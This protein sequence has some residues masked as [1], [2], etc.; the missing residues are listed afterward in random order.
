MTAFAAM[1][2]CF[3]TRELPGAALNR[4]RAAHEV[5]TW[6]AREPPARAELERVERFAQLAVDNL[7][8]SDE[9]LG[10][11]GTPI[12]IEATTVDGASTPLS[13]FAVAVAVAISLMFV[14][15]LLAAG[16]LALEREENA[17]RRLVRGLVSPSALLAE[18]ALLAAACSTLVGL[19]M[20]CGL[21]LFV[22]LDWGRFPLWLAALAAG[23]AGFAALG[24]AIGALAR[25]VR[26]ASLLAFMLA[27]PVAFLALVPSGAV[28]A[29]LYDAIRVVSALFPFKPTLDAMDAALNDAG[30]IGAPLLHLAAL[31]LGLGALAR[32]ALRRFA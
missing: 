7:D 3:V 27:L 32:L 1:A 21:A 11:I 29:G 23:S 6:P 30:G 8:L 13:S 18:K 20:L 16:T 22:D 12:K 19:V 17:F 14:T 15:V 10:T 4:L 26:A 28:S 24:L 31:T 9:I 2:R 5:E 25:E